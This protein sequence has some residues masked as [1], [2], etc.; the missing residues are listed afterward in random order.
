MGITMARISKIAVV[1]VMI[2]ILSLLAYVSLM[3]QTAPPRLHAATSPPA[4]ELRSHP[5]WPAARPDDVSSIHNIVEAFFDAISA[6]KGGTLDRD[7]LRSL[8]VPNGRIE[9]PIPAAG[10]QPTDV[11]FMSSDSY[12][13]LSDAGTKTEGFFDHALA[14]QVQHFGVMAHVYVSYESRKNRNDTKP[15]VR[16]M[17]S[18]ELL[19]TGGRWYITQVAWDRERQ[20]NPIPEI[21]L[22]DS[23]Q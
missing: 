10:A 12:A 4:R 6:D 16:G 21:Y 3:A 22:H 19:E 5:D 11:M 9:I 20:G 13:D 15:F 14:M 2:V 7:R 8:F 18:F 1:G 23:L 17:K